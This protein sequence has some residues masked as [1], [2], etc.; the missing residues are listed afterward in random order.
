MVKIGRA[1]R[2]DGRVY[3]GLLGVILSVTVTNLVFLFLISSF[4]YGETSRP[5]PSKFR[6]GDIIW[7]KQ[8]DRWVP[9]AVD[10]DNADND[11]TVYEDNKQEW[12]KEKE[13]FIQSVR[14][15]SKASDHELKAAAQLETISFEDFMASFIGNRTTWEAYAFNYQDNFPTNRDGIRPFGYTTRLPI[16][17]G[18]VG[19]IFKKDGVP[20]V[21]DAVPPRVRTISY[22][23]WLKE[24]KD[25]YVWHGRFKKINSTNLA[26]IVK[27]ACEQKDQPFGI[28]NR[29]LNDGKKFYCS[30]LIWF[31]VYRVTG[32]A[33]DGE[34]NPDR[35]GWFSPKQLMNLK[36][37]VEM[38]YSPGEY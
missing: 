11:N 24:Y 8:P 1:D 29:N 32:V 15:N 27:K 38:I 19:M 31:S 10:L 13:E 12:E 30:K 7:P 21:V 26:E 33:L 23:E 9:Y 18:H 5:D 37:Q 20:W 4:G 35:Y 17:V 6:D 22:N 25:A 2:N 16:Y 36:E 3:G 14:S 28:F 34:T